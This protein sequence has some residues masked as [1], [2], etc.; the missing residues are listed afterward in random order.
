M[1][2]INW[3][4][5]Y[6]MYIIVYCYIGQTV[7]DVFQAAGLDIQSSSSDDICG[8][9][10]TPQ[11]PTYQHISATWIEEQEVCCGCGR[12]WPGDRQLVVF[13]EGNWWG[14][15]AWSFR[16]DTT[17]KSNQRFWGI[18]EALLSGE[19]LFLWNQEMWKE[20]LL[21]LQISIAPTWDLYQTA[22]FPR[23]YA[24]GWQSLHTIPRCTWDWHSGETSALP[25]MFSSREKRLP[26]FPSVQHVNNCNMML[27]CDECGMWRLVYAKSKLK[28]QEHNRL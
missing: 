3:L 9:L 7:I 13:V 17:K 20:C 22:A 27:M 28:T 14:V 21:Y 18:L 8:W 16:Q 2:T 11:D 24:Q 5:D 26:F 19:A 6:S 15:W 12:L 4:M 25:Q 1:L 10:I 23:S